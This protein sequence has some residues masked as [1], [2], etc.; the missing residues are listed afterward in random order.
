MNNIKKKAIEI[1]QQLS[2]YFWD[3]FDPIY[4]IYV[5]YRGP[6][7]RQKEQIKVLFVIAELG[8]WKTESL[9]LEMKNHPRFNALLGVTTSM[10]VPG[11]KQPL[12]AYLD[13]KGYPYIDLDEDRKSVSKISPDLLFYYKP[14]DGSYPSQHLFKKHIP[15]LP[16]FLNYA[17]TSM[18]NKLYVTAQICNY[19]WFVF[20]ENE[21]VAKRKREVIGWRA[22]NVRVTGI[23]M[24]D[25][26]L[27]AQKHSNNPW[28]DKTGRK[29]IIY[30][31]H[32]S[33]KGTNGGGKETGTEYAT[34]LE[35]GEFMLQLAEKYRDKAVFAFKPHPTLY[36]KLL[37]IWGKEKTDAY[38]N[39][40]K[41]REYTQY[42]P[43][44]YTGL[45]MHSDAMIHDC[46]SFQIE[47]HY[48]HNPVMFLDAAN[49]RM[50]DQNEF[51]RLAFKMHY[52]GRNEED[53]ERFLQNVI[54]G[55]DPMKAERDEF[56][57][58]YLLPPNGKRA[59][60]NIIDTILGNS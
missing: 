7:I 44:E 41:S 6:K 52:R 26:L 11:S 57:H 13:Q 3:H 36:V 46:G 21:L 39:E 19:S 45:F 22:N 50:E 18:G 48:T 37:K 51:G 27:D 47:Y 28:D 33:F 31:P 2:M 9:Y 54:Q 23:P 15:S 20:V 30:A 8:A 42:C 14:Y 56:Y 25:N 1:K 32:H 60:E 53:I 16:C 12:Q 49:Y 24:Q 29:R 55:V 17:F 34:F 5:S 59:S 10:E 43:G 40:W 38:Y 4:R 58:Q 35:F